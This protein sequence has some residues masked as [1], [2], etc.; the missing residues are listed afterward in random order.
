[1]VRV[2]LPVGENPTRPELVRGHRLTYWLWKSPPTHYSIDD[3][4]WPKAAGALHNAVS[5]LGVM[6][7]PR[8]SGPFD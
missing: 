5:D 6:V 4:N 2:N 7:L 3:R 8:L 1:V